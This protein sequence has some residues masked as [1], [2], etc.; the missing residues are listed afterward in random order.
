MAGLTGE[1]TLPESEVPL[2][3]PTR[4]TT[5]SDWLKRELETYDEEMSGMETAVSGAVGDDIG[6]ADWLDNL[7]DTKQSDAAQQDDDIP[8]WL[9]SSDARELEPLSAT[10]AEL[11]IFMGADDA[12][13][14]EEDADSADDGYVG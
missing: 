13:S 1:L 4:L 3:A 12:V 2:E 6:M 9:M 10:P 8:D 14:S 5:D 7:R 11:S